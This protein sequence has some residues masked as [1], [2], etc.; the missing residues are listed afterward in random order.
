MSDETLS[1]SEVAERIATSKDPESVARI[2]RQIRYWTMMKALLPSGGA[3]T[4]RGKHRRYPKEELYFAAVLSN[5]ASMGIAVGGLVGISTALRSTINNRRG[6]GPE[7]WQGAINGTR[8]VHAVVS[9]KVAGDDQSYSQALA[10]LFD[11][12]DEKYIEKVEDGFDRGEYECA[13]ML[14]LTQIF[15]RLR[16]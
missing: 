7:L 2:L 15:S 10:G 14:R 9:F 13:Y 3:F 16:E 1:V 12:T 6:L 5:A 8:N 4:G 11:I